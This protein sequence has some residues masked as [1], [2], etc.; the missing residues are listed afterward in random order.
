[1]THGCFKVVA[2]IPPISGVFA[3]LS[4]II[5]PSPDGV[6]P[7]SFVIFGI[8]KMP[9]ARSK[10]WPVGRFFSN[11]KKRVSSFCRREEDNP[12]DGA[13]EPLC[14]TAKTRLIQI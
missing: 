6:F 10:T 12:R 9:K 1:M 11:L 3:G 14:L 4:K 5:L 8:G 7:E 2:L 13:K